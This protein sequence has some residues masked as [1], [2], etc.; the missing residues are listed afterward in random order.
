MNDWTEIRRKVLVEK[1]SIRQI[2]RD[3]DVSHHTVRKMLE[4]S[5]PP[6]YQRTGERPRPKLDRYLGVIDQ[7]LVDDRD[8]PVKQRHSAKRIF[9]RLRDE[10]GYEGSESHVRR[11]VAQ[12]GHRH[13]EVFVPLTQPPA[14]PS[15]TSVRLRS[16]LPECG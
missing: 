3:Y 7:I 10:H 11:Y 15:S 6:G 9:E 14:R 13:R 4:I 2:C 8:A 16:T 5:E 12:V 1:V